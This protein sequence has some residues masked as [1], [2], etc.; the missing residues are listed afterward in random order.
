[1]SAA[2]VTMPIHPSQDARLAVYTVLMAAITGG[3]VSWWALSRGERRRGLALPLLLAGGAISV[4][5]EPLL[6][7]VVLFWYPPHQDLGAFHAFGRTVPICVVIGYAW[8]C[9]GL[10]YFAARWFERGITVRGVWGIAAAVYVVDFVAIGLTSWLHIAGFYGGQPFNVAGYPLWWGAV[11]VVIVIAG[12]AVIRALTPWLRGGSQ[13][14]YAAVPLIVVGAAGG[15]VAAPVSVALNSQ[16]SSL[17]KAVAA[18]ITLA[19]GAAIVQLV[20]LFVAIPRPQASR[21]PEP[22]PVPEPAPTASAQVA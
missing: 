8:F 4:V 13:L 5:C 18:L 7:N 3:L 11:D 22:E 12:G 19:I 17:G 2:F 15:A 21:A 14:V 10:P 16:W 20:T 1:M 6:D 9:G